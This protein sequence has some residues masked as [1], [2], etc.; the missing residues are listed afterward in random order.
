VFLVVTSVPPAVTNLSTY[1]IEVS[2]K[3]FLGIDDTPECVVNR[4]GYDRLTGL[5]TG[6][7]MAASSDADMVYYG[8]L[9]RDTS[10]DFCETRGKK[11]PDDAERVWCA[12]SLAGYGVMQVELT[13]HRDEETGGYLKATAPAGGPMMRGVSGHCDPPEQNIILSNYQTANDGGAASPNG[14]PI[15]DARAVDAG[16]RRI[17]FVAG[18]APR[19]RVGTYPPIGPQDGWT[20]RVIRKIP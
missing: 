17:T 16:G 4:Q 7:E 20:L 1:E 9:R 6:A 19:L 12:V 10:I 15:D 13:V 14:Q 2:Y 8:T 3:G 11:S 18:G 5:V